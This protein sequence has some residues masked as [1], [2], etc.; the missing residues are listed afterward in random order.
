M[1]CAAL[2][3]V[4]FNFG[5]STTAAAAAAANRLSSQY[6]CVQ[7]VRSSLHLS[8]RIERFF[9]FSQPQPPAI[10]PIPA[11][12]PYEYRQD[13][14]NLSGL[15]A[16]LEC[17]FFTFQRL[18][19]QQACDT[20]CTVVRLGEQSNYTDC[21][22]Y[23]VGDYRYSTRCLNPSPAVLYRV[24][25]AAYVTLCAVLCCPVRKAVLTEHTRCTQLKM[26]QK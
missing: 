17:I 11:V 8:I 26:S 16:T 5:I 12:W 7:V 21:L 25:Y 22:L 6:G 23:T 19:V 13:S 9:L 1:L 14:V 20:L 4:A 2:L 3:P 15:T 24:P 10:Q 18:G